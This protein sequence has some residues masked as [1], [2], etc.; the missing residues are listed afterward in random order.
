MVIHVGLAALGAILVLMFAHE[1][2]LGAI[3]L[4]ADMVIHDL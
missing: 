3:F 1:I 2:D 4:A